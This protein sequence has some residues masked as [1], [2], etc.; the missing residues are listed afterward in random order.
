MISFLHI[1]E[2]YHVKMTS[3]H[4]LG[5][6]INSLPNGIRPNQKIINRIVVSEKL[7]RAMENSGEFEAALE[8]YPLLLCQ[9]YSC[10]LSINWLISGIGNICIPTSE[11]DSA[12]ILRQTLFDV[13]DLNEEQLA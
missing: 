5:R 12:I 8:I 13:N 2:C 7:V 3:S 10:G 4:D 1:F 11:W 6:L 9:L